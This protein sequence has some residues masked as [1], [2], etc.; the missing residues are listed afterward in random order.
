MK[1]LGQE[2]EEGDAGIGN[3][4]KAFQELLKGLPEDDDQTGEKIGKKF[5]DMFENFNDP[6]KFENA[7]TQLLNEFMDKSLLE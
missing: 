4:G 3:L 6:S 7:A 1:Q 5:T 2:A